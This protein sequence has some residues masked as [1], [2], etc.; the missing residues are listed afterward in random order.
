[1]KRLFAIALLL[2]AFVAFARAGADED[3]VG[4]YTMIQ[5]GDTLELLHPDQA[6]AKFTEAQTALQR[7]QRIYPGWND[8][9][10]NFRLSYLSSK[11]LILSAK[12]SNSSNTPAVAAQSKPAPAPIAQPAA[13]P[14]RPPDWVQ[15]PVQPPVT[16]AATS[17]APALSPPSQSSA[18]T[19]LQRQ[20]AELQN[21][22]RRLQDDKSLL[23]AKLREAL[24]ARPAGADPRKLARAQ[25]LIRML[26]KDNDLL[27]VT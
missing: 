25:D 15:A 23:E 18:N 6:L 21:Q 12:T 14:V 3:Y 4:I 27:Q 8:R 10:V 24:A 7:F 19:E 13:P 11:I 16:R 5:E 17:P 26:Q 1:M 9:V 22:L 2:L 20:I